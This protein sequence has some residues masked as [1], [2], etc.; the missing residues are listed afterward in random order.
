MKWLAELPST[1]A[2]ILTGIV[3]AFLTTFRYLLSGIKFW[4]LTVPSWEPSEFWL[5]FC[6]T[7]MGVAT[8]QHALKR[9]SYKSIPPA[10]DRE[11]APAI[12]EK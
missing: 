9:F 1:N 10:P 8:T 3:I 12:E 6:V 2:V 5:L 7:V 11:D 4:V